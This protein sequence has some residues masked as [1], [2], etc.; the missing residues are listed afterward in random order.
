MLENNQTEFIIE[1]QNLIKSS[2]HL[3]SEEI[4]FEIQKIMQQQLNELVEI[5]KNQDL[6]F[7]QTNKNTKDIARLE[8]QN[9]AKEEQAE[10]NK[11]EIAWLKNQ[12]KNL[13]RE[14]QKLKGLSIY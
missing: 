12:I 9:K 5:R 4:Q 3:L 8:E 6:L 7:A 1:I 11:A 13:C 10:Q 14:Q 2:P